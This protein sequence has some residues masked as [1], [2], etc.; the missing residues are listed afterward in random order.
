M[1]GRP[2]KTSRHN[3]TGTTPTAAPASSNELEPIMADPKPQPAN[4]TLA[5]DLRAAADWLDAHAELPAPNVDAYTFGTT[6]RFDV[7]TEEK[8]DSLLALT[9]DDIYRS[10]YRYET[11]AATRIASGRLGSDRLS[12]NVAIRRAQVAS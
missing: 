5:A 10:D 7:D 1:A 2:T 11:G 3:E 12:L 9:D 8:A 6:I 4:H